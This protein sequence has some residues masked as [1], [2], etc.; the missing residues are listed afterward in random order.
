MSS[1][2]ENRNLTIYNE[3]HYFGLPLMVE[4]GP[5][6][7]EYLNCLHKTIYRALDAYREVFAFRFELYLP[8]GYAQDWYCYQNEIVDR[9][10]DSFKAKIY[11]NRQIALRNHGSAHDTKVRFVWTRETGEDG[12]PHYHFAVLLNWDA[13]CNIGSYELGRSNMFNRLHEAWATA[14]RVPVGAVVSAVR[15][16]DRPCYRLGRHRE[17]EVANFFYRASYLC[18]AATKSFGY[19]GHAFGA[20]RG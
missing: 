14:L 11:H 7:L 5:F 3:S 13:F 10:V 17:Q 18:K 9:F 19:G 8:I 6:I 16:S 20:S 15:M 1:H 4:K 2:A 12:G